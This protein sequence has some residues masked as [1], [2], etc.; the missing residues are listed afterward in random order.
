M[1]SV[2]DEV[3]DPSLNSNIL[4]LG[5]QEEYESKRK[6][7]KDLGAKLEDLQLLRKKN[8]EE[9]INKVLEN[10]RQLLENVNNE[11]I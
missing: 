9:L 2:W 6:V 10:N 3:N 5:L 1:K 8:K 11:L 4:I 7:L